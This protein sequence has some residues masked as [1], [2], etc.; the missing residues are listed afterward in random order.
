MQLDS[1]IDMLKAAAEP[2]RFRLLALCARGPITV[3]ELVVVLGQS[4]PRISRHLKLLASAGLIERHRN[5]KFVYY[6]VPKNGESF[7]Q[8]RMILSLVASN[9]EQLE[10]DLDELMTRTTDETPSQIQADRLFNRAILDVAATGAIGALLDIGVGSARIMKLLASHATR[11]VGIDNNRIARQQARTTLNE[12]GLTNCSVLNGDMYQLP[13][14]YNEFDTVIMDEVLYSADEAV[15]ALTE[16][17][18]TLCEHGRLIILE[19]FDLADLADAESTIS[20]WIRQS[21]LSVT[22]MRPVNGGHVHWL[23]VIAQKN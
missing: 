20:T 10:A 4:Q 18:R 22:S 13:F 23:I 12:A 2:T 16:A 14:D 1:T 21:N 5:G 15:F 11:L 17:A 3:S 7:R 8:A 19:K 6:R 9:D